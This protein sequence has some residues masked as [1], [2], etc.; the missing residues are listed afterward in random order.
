V[1]VGFEKSAEGQIDV[2]ETPAQDPGDKS[3]NPQSIKNEEHHNFL[4]VPVCI[5]G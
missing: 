4:F 5:T 2:P 1:I 3:E